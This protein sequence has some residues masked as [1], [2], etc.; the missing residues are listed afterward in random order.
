MAGFQLRAWSQ[1]AEPRVLRVGRVFART[2]RDADRGSRPDLAAVRTR[3][4]V[5][6]EKDLIESARP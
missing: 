1:D 6:E 3:A 4:K 2:D 5:E